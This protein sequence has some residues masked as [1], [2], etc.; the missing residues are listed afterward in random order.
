MTWNTKKGKSEV[1]ESE[2]TSAHTFVLAGKPLSQVSE[3]TYL[4]ISLGPPGI[5]DGNTIKRLRSAK[6]AVHQL[7]PLGVFAKGMHILNS[8]ESTRPLYNPDRNTL[9]ISL[10]GQVP[11]TKT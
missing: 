6:A 9:S 10:R 7:K 5:T 8:F 2:E 4:G 11:S 3:V 1:L